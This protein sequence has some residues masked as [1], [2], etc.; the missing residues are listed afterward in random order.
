MRTREE[1]IKDGRQCG[2]TF[3]TL[4]RTLK[5]AGLS[6]SDIRDLL[7]EKLKEDI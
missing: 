7:D 5:E 6:E 4:A 1:I 2:T 3:R